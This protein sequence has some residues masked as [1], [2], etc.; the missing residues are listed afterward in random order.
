MGHS[1]DQVVMHQVKEQFLK[2]FIH[3]FPVD[4]EFRKDK[5]LDI[6][7]VAVRAHLV[8]DQDAHFVSLERFA[9]LRFEQHSFIFSSY[10]VVML[11]FQGFVVWVKLLR[12]KLYAR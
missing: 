2:V 10:D 4:V 11:V 3:S 8:D 9:C 6:G 7:L 12:F 1:V 5:F